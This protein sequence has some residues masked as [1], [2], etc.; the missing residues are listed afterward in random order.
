MKISEFAIFGS[1]LTE[2]K[3]ILN[4][5][6]S[7]IIRSMQNEYFKLKKHV[8][9]A[10]YWFV[11]EFESKWFYFS[12]NNESMWT[13]YFEFWLSALSVSI[14]DVLSTISKFSAVLGAWYLIRNEWFCL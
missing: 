10:E 13:H 7:L 9:E 14:S 12:N 4:L 5:C 11:H 8:T 3:N 6:L 2:I 1:W